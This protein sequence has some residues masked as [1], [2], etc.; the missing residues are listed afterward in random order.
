MMDVFG[1]TIDA[2][3]ASLLAMFAIGVYVLFAAQRRAD[4]D[5]GQA[6]KDDG[7]KVSALRLAIFVAIAVS[8]WLIIFVTMNVIKDGKDLAE[9]FPFY[10]AYLGDLVRHQGRGEGDRRV[11]AKFGIIGRGAAAMKRHVK[12][13]AGAGGFI[14]EVWIAARIVVFGCAR[15]RAAAEREAWRA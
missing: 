2:P 1:Y 7:G 9:L 6:L 4:F 15:T 12:I 13:Y 11:L 3:A 14:Y 8:S 10:M 5:W